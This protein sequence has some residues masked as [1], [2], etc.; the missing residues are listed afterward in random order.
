MSTADHRE[1]VISLA[2]VPALAVA[3]GAPGAAAERGTILLLHGLTAAKE[4][5]RTEASSLADHGYLAV[6][7]DAV[8]HGA[9]RYADFD[10]RFADDR[11]EASFFE[12]VRRTAEEIPAVLA[13]LTDLG[14]TRPGRVGACGISMGGFILFGA[15]TARC[16]LD[17]VATIVASPR[18]LHGP[19]SPHAELDRFFPTPL[20][21]QTGAHDPVVPPADAHDL[22]EAL[23][24]RYASAPDRLRYLEHAGEAHMFSERAWRRAW[25]EVPTWFDR[26]LGGSAAM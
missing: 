8:G 1:Q 10:A 6:T 26:H 25:G 13:A 14:W 12:V 23:A 4:V 24:P 7:I 19:T 22:H 3:S 11:G 18:W 17:A 15:I 21:M 5:Q 20:L 9:R 2:G 16:A